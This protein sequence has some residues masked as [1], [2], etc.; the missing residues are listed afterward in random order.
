MPTTRIGP[1]WIVVAFLVGVGLGV[2]LLAVGL[3][4]DPGDAKL[5]DWIALALTAAL[6]GT[7]V[8]SIVVEVRRDR[9]R[10][11][12][13]RRQEA[14]RVRAADARISVIAYMTRRTLRTWVEEA[15]P[16]NTLL[17]A[18]WIQE[19]QPHFGATEHRFTD[20][21]AQAPDASAGVVSAVRKAFILF[22]TATNS[23]NH[24]WKEGVVQSSLTNVVTAHQQITDGA[25]A[26]DD[27]IDRE[28]REH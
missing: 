5:T 3:R 18:G 15:A 17:A 12:D 26:L 1:A 20:M 13:L 10:H 19:V 7:A 4:L 2:L 25:A 14:D 27:S 22:A 11:E 8:V 24:A 21:M 28:L 23:M 16:E 9:R 6:V